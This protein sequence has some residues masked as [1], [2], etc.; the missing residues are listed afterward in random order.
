VV[1]DKRIS[2]QPDEVIAIIVQTPNVDIDK[3]TFAF[4]FDI[5]SN[6]TFFIS[7]SL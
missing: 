4:A 6:A 7:L 2:E 1:E 5:T 3:P